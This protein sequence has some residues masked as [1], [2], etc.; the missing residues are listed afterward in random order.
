MHEG[1]SSRHNHYKA[2]TQMLEKP[3][4]KSSY[5]Q[6]AV[7]LEGHIMRALQEPVFCPL[8]FNIFINDLDHGMESK[9]I[10][11]VDDILLEIS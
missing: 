2:V 5:Q 1:L 3:Y 9:Y 4:A 8:L 6:S 10:K 11:F 7:K